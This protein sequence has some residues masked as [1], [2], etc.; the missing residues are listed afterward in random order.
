MPI[1]LGLYVPCF[2]DPKKV[3]KAYTH[4]R[5]LYLVIMQL[6]SVF[7]ET[8]LCNL[9]KSSLWFKEHTIKVKII[10]PKLIG[11]VTSLS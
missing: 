7:F 5:L 2:V 8:F 6:M 10:M 9:D 1:H 3:F 4:T 11:T